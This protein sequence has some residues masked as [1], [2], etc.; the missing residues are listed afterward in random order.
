MV[1]K[2]LLNFPSF[3]SVSTTTAS[4]TTTQLALNR[5]TDDSRCEPH[6]LLSIYLQKKLFFTCLLVLSIFT[7]VRFKNEECLSG[8]GS[9]GTCY[10]SGQSKYLL[11]LFLL[12]KVPGA[13]RVNLQ[14][15]AHLLF[16]IKCVLKLI[17]FQAPPGP[18]GGR[19]RG[20]I[21]TKTFLGQVGMCVQNCV[22]ISGGV[23]IS[24]SPPHTNRQTEGQTDK[25]LYAH[26]FILA[27]VPGSALVNM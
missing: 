18:G 23:S 24:I 4:S 17:G 7:V 8:T 14:P 12:A 20:H 15:A 25:H 5:S 21:G 6:I 10:S 1:R 13:D 22:K 19:E 26:F 11:F 27:E 9:N 2:K 16:C 3:T